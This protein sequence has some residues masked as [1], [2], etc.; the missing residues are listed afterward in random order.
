MNT[1]K[2]ITDFAIENDLFIY[3]KITDWLKGKQ[4]EKHFFYCFCF[5][6]QLNIIKIF[7][8]RFTHKVK[9]ELIIKLVIWNLKI[10]FDN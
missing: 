5:L 9:E 1:G 2:K 3:T 6:N 7:Q 8:L 10:D 4:Q